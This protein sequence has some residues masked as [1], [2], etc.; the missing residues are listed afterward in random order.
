MER[1]RPILA[2]INIG[3]AQAKLG[4][5]WSTLRK[6]WRKL[7]KLGRHPA[8]VDQ[9]RLDLVQVGPPQPFF[10]GQVLPCS[11]EFVTAS[12]DRPGCFQRNLEQQLQLSHML[13]VV[14]RCCCYSCLA[15]LHACAGVAAAP[16]LIPNE[17]LVVLRTASIACPPL[18]QVVG[19]AGAPVAV[20]MSI[21]QGGTCVCGRG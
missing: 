13:A 6:L 17:W 10:L 20:N 1:C 14:Q 3:H 5:H 4:Q 11:T 7:S 19:L 12:T 2:R 16:E 15:N 21:M 8:D 9:V 18:L